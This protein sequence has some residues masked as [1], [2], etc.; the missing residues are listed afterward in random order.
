MFRFLR[1]KRGLSREEILQELLE[2]W[3]K[4]KMLAKDEFSNKFGVHGVHPQSSMLDDSTVEELRHIFNTLFE[5]NSIIAYPF[6]FSGEW[7]TF[8]E[9][10]GFRTIRIDINPFQIKRQKIPPQSVGIVA[11]ADNIGDFLRNIDGIVA[12]EPSS[13]FPYSRLWSLISLGSMLKSVKENGKVVLI[14]GHSLK[15][16]EQILRTLGL[17]HD[18]YDFPLLSV[19][20]IH[21]RPSHEIQK[22][23]RLSEKLLEGKFEELNEEEWKLIERIWREVPGPTLWDRIIGT[24]RK[25]ILWK[26]QAPGAGFEPARD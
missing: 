9:T 15:R 25:Y 19:Y 21:K 3:E 16:V 14:F 24:L 23:M 8:L 5:K 12:F 11:D 10:L 6:S 17:S 20:V 4:G 22:I 13:F 7:G 26:H 18:K 1:R 2:E